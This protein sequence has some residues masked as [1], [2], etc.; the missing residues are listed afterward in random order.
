MS[1]P[2]CLSLGPVQS[3][4]KTNQLGY[5]LALI[6]IKVRRRETPYM[7]CLEGRLERDDPKFAQGCCVTTLN[8]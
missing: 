5:A 4:R 2:W 8:P 1:T 3:Q 6:E 7:A